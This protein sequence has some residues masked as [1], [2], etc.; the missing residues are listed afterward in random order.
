MK[1]KKIAEIRF[2]EYP[3]YEREITSRK[4]DMLCH[5]EEDVNAWIRAK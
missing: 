2:R 1:D 5:K 4:F 3:Y